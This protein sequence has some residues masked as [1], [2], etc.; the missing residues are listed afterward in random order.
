MVRDKMRS[1]ILSAVERK[2]LAHDLNRLGTPRQN[3]AIFRDRNPELSEI[4]T[5]RAPRTRAIE[6][7]VVSSDCTLIAFV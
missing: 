2:V 1:S 7:D 5:G 6:C 4:T 3:V